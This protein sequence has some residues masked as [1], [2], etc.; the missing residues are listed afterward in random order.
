MYKDLLIWHGVVT[1]LVSLWWIIVPYLKMK[2]HLVTSK[3]LFMLGYM[4]F[5][6]V[7]SIQAAT[8]WDQ[9]QMA[10]YADFTPRA[11][12]AYIVLSWVFFGV[13]VL[14]Y[15]N[16]RWVPWKYLTFKSVPATGSPGFSLFILLGLFFSFFGGLVLVQLPGI[17]QFGYLCGQPLSI[18]VAALCFYRWIQDKSNPLWAGLACSSF[19]MSLLLSMIGTTGRRPLLSLLLAI[20][21]IIYWTRAQPFTFRYRI[22]L[23]TLAAG[24]IVGQLLGGYSGIRHRVGNVMMTSRSEQ[25]RNIVENV[26]MTVQRSTR[27]DIMLSSGLLGGDTASISVGAAELFLYDPTWE[28]RPLH[29][30]MAVAVNPVPR[31]VWPDKPEALGQ[32][33]PR[34]LGQW[35]FGYINW[36]PGIVA[37]VVQDVFWIAVWLY[38]LLIGTFLRWVDD[39]LSGYP[40]NFFMVAFVT[41]VSGHIIAFPRGDLTVFTINIVGGL[42]GIYF[43]LFLSRMFMRNSLTPVSQTTL[44]PTPVG[45]AG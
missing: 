41:S 1:I 5:M 27:P 32:T 34:D 16:P 17:A 13:L 21:I 43:C 29:S 2:E 19:A 42:V 6:G 31:A 9:F 3:N 30:L 37:H 12:M 14:S 11:V 36:G 25:A 39:Q 15:K 4:N 44:N 33:F 7:S 8:Y 45:G 28:R 24:L 23:T 40:K 10:R 22:V 18:G 20:V 38:P 26:R 35:S